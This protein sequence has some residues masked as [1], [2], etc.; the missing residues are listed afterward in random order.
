MVALSDGD[1]TDSNQAHKKE[2]NF[3][4]KKGHYW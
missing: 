1:E 4:S 2:R 3:F